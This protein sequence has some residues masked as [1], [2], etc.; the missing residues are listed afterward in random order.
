MSS[1]NVRR[2][3]RHI[4]ILN[5]PLIPYYSK[6]GK[7]CFDT[8]AKATLP[9]RAICTYRFQSS[10]RDLAAATA[11]GTP[12]FLNWPFRWAKREKNS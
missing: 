10:I 12:P 9:E 2:I 8:L 7:I 1:K 3:V 11:F 4:I 5:V 6:P